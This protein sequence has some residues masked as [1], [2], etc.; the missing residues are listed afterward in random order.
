M[1]N[2]FYKP[3]VPA[4]TKVGQI[5]I[6]CARDIGSLKNTT[7]VKAADSPQAGS[8]IIKMD[9]MVHTLLG[10]FDLKIRHN[11]CVNV[12]GEEIKCTSRM[13]EKNAAILESS[14]GKH[15]AREELYFVL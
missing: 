12:I 1:I 9:N 2:C 15:N 10:R 8:K 3:K 5:Q 13:C 7:V 14:G 11:K 6:Q 4:K